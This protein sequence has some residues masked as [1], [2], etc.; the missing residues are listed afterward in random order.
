MLEDVLILRP[1]Y[2]GNKYQSN[3]KKKDS[4][5]IDFIGFCKKIVPYKGQIGIEEYFNCS[6]L[7]QINSK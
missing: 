1:S 5:I 7:L 6:V 3:L 2:Q 4:Q